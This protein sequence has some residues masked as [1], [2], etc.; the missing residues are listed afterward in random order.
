MNGQEQNAA[1]VAN[2]I[3][4]N[5]V[6]LFHVLVVAFVLL[7]PFSNIPYFLI[8]HIT[9][10]MSLL[11]H[12]WGNSD[13][14]SL[15]VMEARLRGLDYTKSFTHKFIAPLYSVSQTTWSNICYAITLFLMAVAGYALYKSDKWQEVRECIKKTK[16]EMEGLDV[17]RRMLKYAKCYN[18]LFVL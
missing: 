1:N 2:Q 3:V 14:C 13:V 5:L 9:F 6:W 15:S 4:A 18:V 17:F 10:S 16:P 12:W 7:G 11:V 8:L